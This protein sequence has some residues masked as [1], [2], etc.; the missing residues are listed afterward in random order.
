MKEKNA[1]ERPFGIK[2]FN[3]K[4]VNKINNYVRSK[5]NVFVH[6][7]KQEKKNKT[8]H[9]VVSVVC[10]QERCY[11]SGLHMIAGVTLSNVSLA[12]IFQMNTVKGLT[13]YLKTTYSF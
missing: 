3:Y 11:L 4:I 9:I 12:N 7:K 13:S 6:L 1:R 2:K 5:G 10:L 8:R